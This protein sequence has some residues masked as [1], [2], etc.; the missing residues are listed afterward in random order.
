MKPECPKLEMTS[1][2][3][4]FYE[5]NLSHRIPDKIFDFHVHINLPEHIPDIS[6]ERIHS[7]WAFE[8]GL[9]LSCETAYCYAGRLF[10]DVEYTIAGFP[11]PIQ[12]AQLKENNDYLL[13]QKK[14]GYLTPFMAVRPDFSETYIE[15]QLPEFCGFKPYPDLVSSVKGAEISIF[16]F[17]PHWQLDILNRHHKTVVIHLPRKERIASSDNVKELL[18]M[19]QKY[20]DI[21]IV[22]AHFGRSFNPVYLKHAL[23]QMGDDIA[24]FYFDTA[25]VLNP[26]VYRLAFEH[27][28]LKQILYGT[29]A[30]IMLWHGRRRWTEDA[31]IN[32]VREPYSWNTHE[33]G[34]QAETGYTFFL[35]EQMNVILDLLDEMK[36]GEE[37]KSGLFYENAARLL[38]LES[39]NR[40]GTSKRE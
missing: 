6:E 15:E 38:K 24:G 28:P 4:T 16:R 25:A 7:D 31:Y 21:Q 33:E 8:C 18:E 23:E 13:E 35:Y 14:R 5:Q 17:M 30:P 26:D 12:E 22:I 32:L 39:D 9:I 29:D 19:R 2:D 11:W 10:P 40:K 36:L 1:I 20:P 3:K 37:V 27:L 34:E